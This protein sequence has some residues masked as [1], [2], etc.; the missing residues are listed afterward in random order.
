MIFRR[1]LR[2]RPRRLITQNALAVSATGLLGSGGVD[3]LA[4]HLLVP[5]PHGRGWTARPRGSRSTVGVHRPTAVRVGYVRWRSGP[6]LEIHAP[7]NSNGCAFVQRV[8]VTPTP[9]RAGSRVQRLRPGRAPTQSRESWVRTLEI[10]TYVG[11]RYARWRSV[12]MLE[13][14]AP[15]NSN[16]CAFVQRV[17]ITPTP[18]RAG[19]RVACPEPGWSAH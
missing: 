14:H 12:R 2:I 19:S 7:C 8:N 4:G 15:C 11:D 9:A 1:W 13:I 10:G 6:T 3:G 17:Y 18:A 16:G 5:R